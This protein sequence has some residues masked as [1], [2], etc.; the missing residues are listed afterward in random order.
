[1]TQDGEMGTAF[2]TFSTPQEAI[3]AWNKRKN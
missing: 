2:V 1:M 3:E